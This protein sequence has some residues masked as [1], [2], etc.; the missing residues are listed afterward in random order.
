[1][2][3]GVDLSTAF[4]VG[5]VILAA[6]L[7]VREQWRGG[8]RF[9]S[10]GLWL[11]F[12]FLV[13]SL[14]ATFVESE[15][16][17]RLERERRADLLLIQ[18][19][20]AALNSLCFELHLQPYDHKY[21]RGC[22]FQIETY[23]PVVARIAGSGLIG[24]SIHFH[25]HPDT[26]W[27]RS[28]GYHLAW[29]SIELEYD[30][31]NHSVRFEMTPFGIRSQRQGVLMWKAER[32]ADLAQVRFGILMGYGIGTESYNLPDLHWSPVQSIYL[33]A[34]SYEP[35]NLIAR[36]LLREPSYG[37]SHSVVAFLPEGQ[38]VNDSDWGRFNIDLLQMRS[39][40]LRSLDSGS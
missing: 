7:V 14:V 40:I 38:P 30:S 19:Q 32:L 31:T 10:W 3:C 21:D 33:Y 2:I 9:R 24:E 16:T 27:F 39:H 17:R 13:V 1:M 26:G 28:S 22:S 29:P 35:E 11:A 25:F 20:N 18:K 8:R 15:S 36:L 6:L 37:G 12:A 4:S 34:N 23:S 5:A